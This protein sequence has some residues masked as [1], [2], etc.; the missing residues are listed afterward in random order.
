MRT[1]LSVAVLMVLAGSFAQ[2]ATL[3]AQ[4][5]HFNSSN[6]AGGFLPAFGQSVVDN[7]PWVLTPGSGN[8]IVG[9]AL[10]MGGSDCAT[11]TVPAGADYGI[12]GYN[13]SAGGFTVV[14]TVSGATNANT[15]E[16]LWSLNRSGQNNQIG[17]AFYNSGQ[18]IEGI[19]QHAFRPGSGTKTDFTHSS[20]AQTILTVCDAPNYTKV[21][22]NG[23]LVRNDDGLRGT[24]AVASS[25]S[26]GGQ[27][28]GAGNRGFA[29]FTVHRI[30]IYAGT[31]DTAIW[32]DVGRQYYYDPLVWIGGGNWSA[33]SADAPWVD[34][35]LVQTPFM[36]YNPVTFN[37]LEGVASATVTVE[38]SVEP[39]SMVFDHSATDYTVT[40]SGEIIGTASLTKR[41]SGTLSFESANPFSGGLVIEGG[42]VIECEMHQHGGTLGTGKNPWASKV[43]LKNGTLNLNNAE[44]YRNG[45]QDG[46]D[47]WAWLTTQTMTLGGMPGNARVENGSLGLGVDPAIVFD[48]TDNPGTATIAARWTL[49]GSSS[50][51]NRT[52]TVGDSAATEVEL[53]FTGGMSGVDFLE[54]CGATIVK[55]GEG[56]MRIS[57]ENYFPALT[58]NAGKVL[59]NSPQALGA[60][61]TT[62]EANSI[63]ANVVTVNAVLD[64]GGFNQSI[65]YL[66]GN[67]SGVITSTD[68]AMLTIGYDYATTTNTYAGA[69]QGAI[70]LVKTGTTALIL[71][72]SINTSGSLLFPEGAQVTIPG[73]TAAAVGAE[74]PIQLGSTPQ[75]AGLTLDVVDSILLETGDHALISWGEEASFDFVLPTVN[76][77]LDNQQL[78]L[79]DER[80]ALV[81]RVPNVNPIVTVMPLGDSITEGSSNS[82]NY[83]GPLSS[84]MFAEGYRPDF[85]G[86]RTIK[87]DRTISGCAEHCGWS[88]ARIKGAGARTG[89]LDNIDTYLDATGYPDVILLMIGTNDLTANLSVDDAFAAWAKLVQRIT[90]L[91][92]HSQVIV[93][94][95]LPFPASYSNA[96]LVPAFNARVAALFTGGAINAE[97]AA[98]FG[99][100]ARVSFVDN[101]AAVPREDGNYMD[102]LHPDWAGHEKMAASWLTGI[103]RVLPAS[104]PAEDA[105]IVR[106]VN[107]LDL[108]Q[109]TITLTYTK[110]PGEPDAADFTLSGEA[111][112]AITAAEP[113]STGRTIV[114]SLD[115][116][117]T[118]G[119][120]YSIN[121]FTFTARTLGAEENVAPELI[122]GYLRVKTLAVPTGNTITYDNVTAAEEL[123]ELF[124]R[125]G[126]Y[127]ELVHANNPDD[128]RYIWVSMDPFTANIAQVGVPTGF[129]LQQ[130]VTN[131]QVDSNVTNV[132]GATGNGIS[133]IIEFTPS[134]I[135]GASAG[136]GFPADPGTGFYGWDDTI[137]ASSYGSMQIF[138]L[139]GENESSTAD[140]PAETLFAFNRWTTTDT[141]ELGI[142]T[143]GT[144]LGSTGGNVT[145]SVDWIFTSGLA[146]F[147][148]SAYT[149]RNMAFYVR[150]AISTDLYWLAGDGAWEASDA[151]QTA[152]SGGSP[153]SFTELDSAIL[154]A[155]GSGE[156]TL[157]QP[158]SARRI[159]V[160][161]NY[162]LIGTGPLAVMQAT[163]QAEGTTFAIDL[164]ATFAGGILGSGS[165]VTS[166]D[167]TVN[168]MGLTKQ[169][170]PAYAVNAG[171]LTIS[172][173]QAGDGIFTGGPSFTV[174][175]GAKLILSGNDVVGWTN[176]NTANVATISGTLEKQVV[177]NETFSGQLT[178]LGN[179]RVVNSGGDDRFMFHSGT[180]L[181]V[182][183]ENADIHFTGNRFKTNNGTTVMDVAASSALTF[184]APLNVALPVNKTG[185]G[186][187]VLAGTVTGAGDFIVNGGTMTL[188]G[189]WTGGGVI[190]AGA[191]GTIRGTGSMTAFATSGWLRGAGTFEGGIAGAGTL[192][193]DQLR[194]FPGSRLRVTFS[195]DGTTCGL[196]KSGSLLF[197]SA[198]STLTVTV[199]GSRRA[200]ALR[201]KIMEV[202][203]SVTL[204]DSPGVVLS[205]AVTMWLLEKEVEGET[206]TWYLKRKPGTVISLY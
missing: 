32:S 14:M 99:A 162:R 146:N 57:C 185:D 11:I 107:S 71:S 52:V 33:N 84:L 21:Y 19:W 197:G 12:G 186:E 37:D 49:T 158:V 97:G 121:G 108:T 131:L 74:A 176:P 55:N 115:G 167:I 180:R 198:E 193:T 85:V 127:L 72:G 28:S 61:H 90:Q 151:W 46:D 96:A 69:V 132:R 114:L 128:L 181:V 192:T 43:T 202:T 164:P 36:G 155:S 51:Y 133:G 175:E 199:A 15:E 153:A 40:G 189:A 173:P 183:G 130:K 178:L 89:L 203:G 102:D 48:A 171:T 169:A 18:S 119:Q 142:G 95:V 204:G 75:L 160:D 106:A 110:D 154:T 152:E 103:Q 9:G 3:V 159:T 6:G 41:G 105:A 134:S 86:P 91:R 118:A 195:E 50:K 206:T 165:V 129:T 34:S 88:G 4:W 184:T 80:T 188:T 94:S 87:P 25:F 27:A 100:Q 10:Q 143:F 137:N 190:S 135:G 166:T 120:V 93:S 157:N 205:D 117:L 64:L 22:R 82:A 150:P 77:L 177:A 20:D 200:K 98:L 60:R 76:G 194:P 59:L 2:A 112:P 83:R 73:V 13:Q 196:L 58:I 122:A 144:H 174:A 45:A 63:V 31:V 172:K 79:N 170:M 104:G 39:N 140:H 116:E 191:N 161:G 201:Y 149:I 44:N 138:R 123:P 54:G 78:V 187:L 30:A 35:N 66:A 16:V 109:K 67:A 124:D 53:D 65:E 163:T 141:N 139:Y 81:V 156:I 70:T 147:D 113:G 26:I 23:A 101:Y 148:A 38:G 47:Y 179:A 56:T 145:A 136:K 68:P 1:Y 17:V 24:F 8:S 168:L 182:P 125:I 29:N 92:P 7:T 62:G 126:Y 5:D 111:A 42:T